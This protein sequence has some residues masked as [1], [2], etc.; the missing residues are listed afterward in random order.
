MAVGVLSGILWVSI[1]LGICLK[2]T[3]FTWHGQISGILINSLRY[4]DGYKLYIA[5][6]SNSLS[7]QELDRFTKQVP[8]E[9]QNMYETQCLK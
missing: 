9:I 3:S 7:A 4:G 1:K 2:N 5:G 6:N 8:L